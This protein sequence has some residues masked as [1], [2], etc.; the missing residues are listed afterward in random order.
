VELGQRGGGADDAIWSSGRRAAGEGEHG[1]G[2]FTGGR[3][4]E[5]LGE[6]STATARCWAMANGHQR[7]CVNVASCTELLEHV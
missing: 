6:E 4:Q 3:E 2:A 5:C 1:G 7:T